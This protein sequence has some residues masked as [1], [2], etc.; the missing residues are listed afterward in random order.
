MV[1]ILVAC[2]L[3]DLVFQIVDGAG[4]FYGFDF[5]AAGADEIVAVLSGLEEC[6][7]GGAL[8]E[9]EAADDAVFREALEEAV[10][11]G[12]VALV[13]K[14]LR[15]GELGEGHGAVCLDEGGEKLFEGF[16][17]AQA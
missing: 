14:A 4:G 12:F 8:V 9:A 15:G 11:G 10:D 5:S 2:L 13:G 3:A 7:V 6:E 17:A 16:C 1:E